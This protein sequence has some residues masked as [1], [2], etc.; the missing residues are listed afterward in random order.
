MDPSFQ[1]F[2]AYKPDKDKDDYFIDNPVLIYKAYVLLLGAALFIA[3]VLVGVS[4]PLLIS[5]YY[6]LLHELSKQ[7]KRNMKFKLQHLLWGFLLTL[8]LSVFFTY[9]F[10]LWHI[11]T[12]GLQWKT[13]YSFIYPM[14]LTGLVIIPIMAV[15]SSIILVSRASKDN[16]F[17]SIP[18]LLYS[19]FGGDSSK[20]WI[21]IFWQGFGVFVTIVISV[22]S[23]FFLCGI[24]LALFADPVQVI[25]FLA[26]YIST[27]LCIV[28]TFAFVFKTTDKII[29]QKVDSTKSRL[30]SY[31]KLFF[32]IVAMVLIT[33]F[34]VI[35]GFIHATIVFFS[36]SGDQLDLFSSVGELIPVIIASAIGWALKNQLSR[37]VDNDT[38]PKKKK[39]SQELELS[40]LNS[41][42][43]SA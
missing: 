10:A 15:M 22:L 18:L 12:F 31:W 17:V 13:V 37:Y 11:A 33:L 20:R 6:P 28:Y 7:E 26:I 32:S 35:Y 34:I 9:I 25:T 8:G 24:L 3:I 23:I 16:T 4:V 27:F 39:Q 5:E 29:N 14:F 41:Q 2:S 43:C 38:N 42:V 36:G 19:I 40:D 21:L 1:G 30:T